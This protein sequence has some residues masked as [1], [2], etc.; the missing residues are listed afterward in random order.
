MLPSSSLDDQCEDRS[1]EP[2]PSWKSVM[3][4]DCINGNRS[5]LVAMLLALGNN[6]SRH[7]TVAPSASPYTETSA[8][9]QKNMKSAAGT[10]VCCQTGL[11]A[12]VSRGRAASTCLCGRTEVK[13]NQTALLHQSRAI[14][15][16]TRQPSCNL[17]QPKDSYLRANHSNHAELLK[18]T[19][20][21]SWNGVG[22]DSPKDL[23]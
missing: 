12:A 6:S 5:D 11:R 15:S 13:N 7:N 22:M 8:R 4:P 3:T 20:E 17:L 21:N 10:C 9:A 23:P 2:D 14:L 1:F 18:K 16:L 19:T